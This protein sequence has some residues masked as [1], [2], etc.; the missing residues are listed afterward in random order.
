M[1][2]VAVFIHVL[3]AMLWVGGLLFLALVVVPAVR[4]LPPAERGALLLAV[5]ERFRPVGWVCIALL[6]GSGLLL[7]GYRGITVEALL[8]GQLPV[9]QFGRL[10]GIKLLLVGGMIGLSFV[11]DVVLGP[12]SARLLARA[13]LPAAEV[14]RLRRRSAW[15]ARLSL[16][17]ALAVVGLA[18]ALT[19]GLPW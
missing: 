10:L 17:L 14:A 11:H 9:S 8:A 6:L 18:V 4:P 1:Y 7:A 16:L 19:R 12:R 5:G 15:T 3:S 2:Q 13:D